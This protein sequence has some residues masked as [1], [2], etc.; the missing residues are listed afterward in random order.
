[1]AIRIPPPEPSDV[2]GP[3]AMVVVNQ[4]SAE[5]R[6]WIETNVEAL[7]DQAKEQIKTVQSEFKE[8]IDATESEF[9]EAIDADRRENLQTAT[10]IVELAKKLVDPSD[11]E[12]LRLEVERVLEERNQKFSNIGGKIVNSAKK[13]VARV[14]GLSILSE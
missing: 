1:M 5:M 8:S 4:A 2:I 3:D 7:R 10:R 14:T 11:A 12:K 6:K 13:A 9:Q